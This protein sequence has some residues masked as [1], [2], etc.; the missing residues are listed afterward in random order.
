[1]IFLIMQITYSSPD[2][3]VKIGVST[4]W[5]Q[6]VKFIPDERSLPTF[7][8]QSESQCLWGTSLEYHLKAKLSRLDREF[9]H[10]RERTQSIGWCR[11]WWDT[12]TGCLSIEDWKI[13]DAMYRSRVMDFEEYGHCLVPVMDMANHNS[14]L[15]YKASYMID[16]R[17]RNAR[18]ALEHERSVKVGD[19]ITILYGEDRS[20]ADS[21]FSYGFVEKGLKNVQSVFLGMVPPE[22]DPLAFAKMTALDIIPGIR[23]NIKKTPGEVEW[24][25]PFVWAMCINEEDG[26]KLEVVK[27]TDGAE[28]L[29]ATWKDEEIIGQEDLRDLL[30]ADMRW[31]LFQLRAFSIVQG[32][33]EE[34]IQRCEELG[35]RPDAEKIPDGVDPKTSVPWKV[36]AELRDR[37]M[38][39]LHKAVSQFGETVFI[40][41]LQQIILRIAN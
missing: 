37:E 21:L 29:R 33:L 20:A 39:L 23:V 35:S 17:T 28:E 8:T 13:A 30:E 24:S 19:E 5:T 4:P 12:E 11:H 36:A 40:L 34:E 41:L 16:E 38:G 27:R 2:I 15:A 22:D 3:P 9:T 7:W 26:L 32:R 18:L 6:Y 1:M 25:G 10:F 31:P 14:A